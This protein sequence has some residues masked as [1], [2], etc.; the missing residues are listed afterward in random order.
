MLKL[1]KKKKEKVNSKDQIEMMWKQKKKKKIKD[2]IDTII[3]KTNINLMG[4]TLVFYSQKKKGFTP[5]LIVLVKSRIYF[6]AH[7]NQNIRKQ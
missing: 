2:W 3:L 1:F 5:P 4:S 7:A 6:M